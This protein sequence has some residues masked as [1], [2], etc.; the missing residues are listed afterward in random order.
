MAEAIFWIAKCKLRGMNQ[1]VGVVYDDATL[2]ILGV[3]SVGPGVGTLDVKVRPDKASQ[4]KTTRL[5]HKADGFNMIEM[6]GL[7]SLTRGPDGLVL[8]EGLD[9]LTV[10]NP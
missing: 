8:P 5:A 3:K 10:W 6:R 9:I 4:V 1:R 2:E 7:G